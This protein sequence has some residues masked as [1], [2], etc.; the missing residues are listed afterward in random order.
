MLHAQN[1]RYRVP[2]AELVA[3]VDPD[4]E[5]AEKAARELDI[6][7]YYLDYKQALEDNNIDAVIIATPT[8][9]HKEITVAAA[10]AKKHILCEKPMALNVNECDEM[11]N[12]ANLHN[13][14][15][16]IGFMRRFDNSF[17]EAERVINSG[18]IGD[19]VMV[20]SLTRGPSIPQKWQYD[21]RISN[22][23]LAEVSSHDIDTL[24]WFTG[25]EFKSV[26]V[27][28]GNYRCPDAKESFPDFY[29]NFVMNATFN[30]GKQGAIDGA[31][32][33]KY[34]YDARVEIV[35]TE[36]VIF[37]GQ[38]HDNSIIVCNKSN[39]IKR[40][41][42]NSWRQLFHSAY[43]NEDT[44]FINCILNDEVPKITGIDGKMAVKVVNAG[45]L[46]IIEE[47]VVNL[48]Y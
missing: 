4:S 20:K 3:I 6:T 31:V 19:V 30:N 47:R 39:E 45:N 14:K 18:E 43:I 12:E 29:D 22:G 1:F 7:R 26:H 35:G 8:I 17:I 25:G 41:A 44:H 36:G 24:R 48:E 13:V 38:V 15:L 46:S 33:V 28:A 42:V 23:S 37:L 9:Y 11:I 32:S 40:P 16:Q 10:N 27:F 2:Y 5:T 21:I 34:G